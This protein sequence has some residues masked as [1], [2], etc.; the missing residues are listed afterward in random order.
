M[1]EHPVPEYTQL[2]E[3]AGL[4]TS[5]LARKADVSEKTARKWERGDPTLRPESYAKIAAAL[6]VSIGEVGGALSP[7]ETSTVNDRLEHIE[8][9]LHSLVSAVDQVGEA[10]LK[11]VREVVQDVIAQFT[12]VDDARDAMEADEAAA[13]EDAGELPGKDRRRAADR[14]RK[15]S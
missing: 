12:A 14:R 13:G 7:E 6:S 8:T 11:A 1:D 5:A 2:R 3:A 10:N 15:A 4:S 9:A